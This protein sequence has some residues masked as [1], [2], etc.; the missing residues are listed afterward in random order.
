MGT[1]KGQWTKQEAWKIRFVA[2]ALI[3]IG[4]GLIFEPALTLRAITGDIVNITS[5]SLYETWRQQHLWGGVGISA[6]GGAAL[7][8]CW[9]DIRRQPQ[10]PVFLPPVAHSFI[11]YGDH[12]AEMAIDR[13]RQDGDEEFQVTPEATKST[14]EIA[15]AIASTC[16]LITVIKWLSLWHPTIGVWILL[17]PIILVWVFV[18]AFL[19]MRLM[20]TWAS[21]HYTTKRSGPFFCQACNHPF[22]PMPSHQ[23]DHYL[24]PKEKKLADIQSVQWSSLYCARWYPELDD[25][26]FSGALP[27]VQ[28]TEVELDPGETTLKRPFHLFELNQTQHDFAVCPNCDERALKKT[29]NI[30]RESTSEREGE[31]EIN[32]ECKMCGYSD[33]THRAIAIRIA[34]GER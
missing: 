21:H 30:L 16:I 8:L 20:Q 5:N 33:T 34:Y 25:P 3:I 12:S 24:S 22:A 7:L 19:R 27:P 26:T 13:L 10:K 32:A 2:I 1:A 17:S 6:A 14:L 28:G 31:L 15:G 18:W 4:I 11:K 29:F 23:L 9:S